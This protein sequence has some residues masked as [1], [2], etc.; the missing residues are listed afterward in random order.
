MFKKPYDEKTRVVTKIVGHSMTH[1]SFKK[2]CDIN[3]ILSKYR[4]TGIV[5]H[6]NRFKGDYADIADVGSYMD[7]LNVVRDASDSFQ[8]LPSEIRKEFDNSPS[9]FLDF[10]KNPENIDKMYDLGL[11][12]RPVSVNIVSKEEINDE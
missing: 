12:I 8:E 7:A 10:V 3:N 6:V 5:E 9:K 4:K 2:E 1:Q 11:A